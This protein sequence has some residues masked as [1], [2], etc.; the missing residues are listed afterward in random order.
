MN[1][2]MFYS[3]FS[4]ADAKAAIVAKVRKIPLGR[5]MLCWTPGGEV[6]AVEWPDRAGVAA[7]LFRSDLACCQDWHELEHHERVVKLW[8]VVGQIICRD[9]VDPAKVRRA[10]V[11]CTDVPLELV[12]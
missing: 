7:H 9:G 2:D 12:A 6:M 5:L 3:L 10:L 8:T 11:A 4:R 1:I